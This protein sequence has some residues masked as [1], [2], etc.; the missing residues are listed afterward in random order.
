MKQIYLDNSASTQVDSEVVE[1]MLPYFTESFGN[2]SSTHQYGQRA[3]QAIEDARGQVALMLNASPTEITLLS[4]GTESDN[5]AIKGIAEAHKDKARGN[6]H[7]ITSQIE[8]PAVLASCAHLEKQ[9]WRVTYL[10]VYREGVV[11]V[12]DVRAMLTD[13][14]VLVTVMHANN[15]IGTIQP[16]QEIAALVKTRREA[17]Q[18]HLYLHTDA[19]QSV[20]KIPVDVRE[21]GVDL[22]TLTAHKIHGPKGIGVLYV[23]KGVRLTSQLHGGHHERDRRAGTESV[24]LIVGIGKA[25]ELVRLHLAERMARA[26][27]LRDY[28][29]DEIFKRIPNVT[30]NGDSQ[31]RV[32]NIANLNFDFVEG[33]GLQISLDL[34]GVA[35]STGSACASG[36]TEPS[37]VLMAI[38]LPRDNGY[39][40]LRFSF[41]KDNTKEDVEHVLEILPAVIEKLRKLS[42]LARQK[43]AAI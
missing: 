34:K 15:E 16:I 5:L 19:V 11:R 37:H 36:S 41:G 31:R 29:E 38:G 8:H 27:E 28:L 14:T 10:P 13:E 35:V 3:K 6:G 18:R 1:A 23:R 2:A 33:E 12:E 21:L 22:L 7:I 39:G 43:Q 42:P 4:G 24:P 25:A 32:P 40:S 30:R 9:G 26:R 17:G 20:G